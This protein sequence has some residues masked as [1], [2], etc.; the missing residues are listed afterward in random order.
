MDKVKLMS[1][2]LAVLYSIG[3]YKL[4]WVFGLWLYVHSYY[5]KPSKM[6]AI[7]CTTST[8]K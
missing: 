4:K 2:L 5:F 6:I 8:T 7:S 3:L 1:M